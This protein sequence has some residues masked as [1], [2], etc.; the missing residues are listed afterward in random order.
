MRF[1]Y[2]GSGESLSAQSTTKRSL[3]RVHSTM[4]FHVVTQLESFATELALERPVPRMHWQMRDERA[5]VRK[6][7]AAELA[8]HYSTAV[9]SG[10]CQL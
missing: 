10:G 7:F 1:Q 8:Q 2:R 6:G 4:V 9:A 5:H 3:T